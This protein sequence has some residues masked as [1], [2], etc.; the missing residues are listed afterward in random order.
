MIV[1]PPKNFVQFV[2]RLLQFRFW[3]CPHLTL[4]KEEQKKYRGN[5]SRGIGSEPLF[6][7]E[8]LKAQGKIHLFAVANLKRGVGRAV[9]NHLP[10][11]PHILK[12]R[13]GL[14]DL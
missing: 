14:P 10:A 9:G 11:K 3:T 13:R 6:A 7:P 12:H 2:S 4:C 5:T 1:I 8:L